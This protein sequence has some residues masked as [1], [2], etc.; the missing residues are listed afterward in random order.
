[1]SEPT[2]VSV[3]TLWRYPIKSM[4]GEELNAS[5]ITALGVLGDRAF[6]PGGQGNRPGRQRQEPKKMAGF[7]RLSRRL[8]IPSRN[9]RTSCGLDNLTFGKGR[10]QPTSPMW[11]PDYPRRSRAP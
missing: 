2:S 1:M 7:L 10:S 8:R 3:S 5:A 4:M 11:T 6:R 9:R